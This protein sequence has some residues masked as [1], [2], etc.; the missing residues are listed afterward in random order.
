[1]E[2]ESQMSKP[3]V[4]L[5]IHVLHEYLLRRTVIIVLVGF[6]CV[7]IS[8]ELERR[9]VRRGAAEASRSGGVYRALGVVLSLVGLKSIVDPGQGC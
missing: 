2:N 6:H 8:C 7:V 4:N 5:N 9:R 3:K 1:M